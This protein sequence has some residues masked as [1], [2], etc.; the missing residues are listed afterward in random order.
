MLR[1][2]WTLLSGLHL[3][4]WRN[5]TLSLSLRSNLRR[6]CSFIN[7]PTFEITFG[8]LTAT[9]KKH[10]EQQ[11]RLSLTN[12]D[13]KLSTGRGCM[14]LPCTFP[15]GHGIR[16]KIQCSSNRKMVCL[17]KKQETSE[18]ARWSL[19]KRGRDPTTRHTNIE[20]YIATKP[21]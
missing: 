11:N 18:R 10:P 1:F 4:S 12:E 5:D 2:S 9:G 3:L 8:L 20:T 14:N 13:E 19:W 7:Q 16:A 15:G 17:L 21:Q 6:A